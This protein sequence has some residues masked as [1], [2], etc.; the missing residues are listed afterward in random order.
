[1]Q[2]YSLARTPSAQR[3]NAKTIVVPGHGHPVSLENSQLCGMICLDG[4]FLFN[5]EVFFDPYIT[6]YAGPR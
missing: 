1:M 5:V 3:N 2:I 4:V 6:V